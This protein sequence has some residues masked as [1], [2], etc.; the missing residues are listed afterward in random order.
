MLD[1]RLSAAPVKLVAEATRWQLCLGFSR[2]YKQ[3]CRCR[4]LNCDFR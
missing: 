2:L 1:R 4:S 3:T